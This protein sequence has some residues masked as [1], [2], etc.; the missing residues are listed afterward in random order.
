MKNSKELL[1]VAGILPKLRLG[2][3]LEK[4]GVQSTGPHLVK[5][6]SDRIQKGKD[7]ETGEVIDVVRYVVDEEGEEK[8]YIVPVKDRETGNLHYLV[9]RLAEV[10]EG[11][12]IT[13][14]MKKRGMKN[15]I[16]VLSADGAPIGEHEEDEVIEEE[17]VI[18]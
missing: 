7:R 12:I 15:Y 10:N 9:Q 17:A 2:K 8:Q 18:E 1:K 5:F 16:E 11:D 14:E 3:K 6:I 4:G 13:L